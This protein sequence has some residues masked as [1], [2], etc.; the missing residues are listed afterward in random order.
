MSK[1]GRPQATGRIAEVL[2]AVRIVALEQRLANGWDYL[3]DHPEEDRPGQSGFDLWLRLLTLY[4]DTC[5]EF[6]EKTG[7]AWTF[8]TRELATEAT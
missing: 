5:R 4:Q 2:L 1:T 8:A 6:H 3:E 7:R